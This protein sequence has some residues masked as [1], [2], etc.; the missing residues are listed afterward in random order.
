M[1]YIT[2]IKKYR[3]QGFFPETEASGYMISGGLAGGAFIGGFLFGKYTS[4]HLKSNDNTMI[5]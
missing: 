1:C 4:D 2:F 5:V 3:W